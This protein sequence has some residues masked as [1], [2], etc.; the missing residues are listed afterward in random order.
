MIFFFFVISEFFQ[1]I[2]TMKQLAA[3]QQTAHVNQSH[4]NLAC[5]LLT[6]P[7]QPVEDALEE[8][9]VKALKEKYDAVREK[10]YEE[11][12]RA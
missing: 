12:L 10:I 5:V 3:L 1:D 6:Q 2:Q 7:P 9:L 4:D 8:E 11:A